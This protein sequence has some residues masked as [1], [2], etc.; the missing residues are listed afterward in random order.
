MLRSCPWSGRKEVGAGF[1]R[2]RA[3]LYGRSLVPHHCA[4]LPQLLCSGILENVPVHSQ[5]P[6]PLGWQS[7]SGKEQ[8]WFG[9]VEQRRREESEEVNYCALS[10]Q[11]LVFLSPPNPKL[12]LF[13]LTLVLLPLTRSTLCVC[14]LCVSLPSSTPVDTRKVSAERLKQ[15]ALVHGFNSLVK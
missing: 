7:I 12:A 1:I 5:A 2:S 9:H 4:A 6:W 8:T 15:Q 10:Y 3:E 14:P 13:P 11:G